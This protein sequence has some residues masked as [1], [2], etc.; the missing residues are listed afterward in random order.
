MTEQRQGAGRQRAQPDHAV[1]L[2][3]GFSASS[4]ISDEA[5]RKA[6]VYVEAEEGA[7]NRL[8][9][10]AAT[11]V[12]AIA[13]GMSLFHLY[14]AIAGVPPLFS[15]FPIV[16]TQPL[17][18]THVA[19]V[20][21]LCFLLF[22]LAD[23]LPQPHP[24]VRRRRR[25][26]RGRDPDLRHRGRRGFHRS[27]D[28]PDPHRRH[29]RRRCSSSSSWKRRAA[30][31][32]GSC[33]RCRSPFIV[34]AM[35]GPYLPPPWNHRGYRHRPAGRAPVHHAGRNF[36]NS[37]RR[38]VEPDHPVHDLRR[39]PAAF[40]RR[41]VLHRLLAEADG[42]QAE[43]RR[44]HGGA[45][46]VPA[47]RAVGL[48]RRH[49]G[50]GRRGRLSDDAEGR[51][52]EE[53]RRRPAGGRRARRDHLAA[54]AGRR[55]LPDRG[56]PQDQLPRRDLDGGDPD[57]PLLPV[58]AVHGRARRPPVRR[59][60]RGDGRGLLLVAVVPLPLAGRDHR[61]HADRALAGAVG[62]LRDRAGLRAE[63]PHPRDR[64]DSRSGW[65]ARCRTARPACSPRPSPAPPPASSSASSR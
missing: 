19:F 23:A 8:V 65:S 45:V 37:G 58:A 44:P 31:S 7:T 55:R 54:G 22:P 32:A 56:V 40:R 34:Y 62:V 41:Q 2:P 17:R 9:G 10:F 5:L 3:S 14:T 29:P 27:R 46:V 6:E 26:G 51:L 28:H 50:D 16:A 30:P 11:F 18:Y 15:E 4:E 53:R 57:L 13:V 21:V 52:R 49:H 42:Q 39:V 1:I 25:R 60:R 61:L 24:V 35:A 38:V 43:R 12:T 20:L 33:R 64:A 36:R 47:R 63:L 59:R 48:G